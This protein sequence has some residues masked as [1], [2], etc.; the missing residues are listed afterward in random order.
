MSDSFVLPVMRVVATG[1]RVDT[2]C[3]AHMSRQ[4]VASWQSCGLLS[5][6]V[7]VR[8]IEMSGPLHLDNAAAT[9]RILREICNMSTPALLSYRFVCFGAKNGRIARLLGLR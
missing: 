5:A 9:L 3:N 4:L 8:R 2:H 7:A 1:L 6:F